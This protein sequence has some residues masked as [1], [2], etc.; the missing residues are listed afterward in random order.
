VRRG[1]GGWGGLAPRSALPWGFGPRSA[2]PAARY[3]RA[4]AER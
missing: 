4:L 1:A 2:A 3:E